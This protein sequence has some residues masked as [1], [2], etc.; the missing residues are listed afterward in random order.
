MVDE[1][2]PHKAKSVCEMDAEYEDGIEGIIY[3]MDDESI[4][5]ADPY[6]YS[7]VEWSETTLYVSNAGRSKAKKEKHG[8][9]KLTIQA[10]A[11][12]IKEK[13][14]EKKKPKNSE[15][16]G[17]NNGRGQGQGS[18]RGRQLDDG[19]GTPRRLAPTMGVSSLLIVYAVPNVGPVNDDRTSKQIA[20]ELFGTPAN[21][22]LCDP[23]TDCTDDVVSAR[24]QALD[25]SRGQLDI[26]PACGPDDPDLDGIC[27]TDTTG[28]IVNG[29]LEVPLTS[30]VRGQSSGTVV[31]WA[32]A[33]ADAV[34]SAT[35]S[36]PWGDGIHLANFTHVSRRCCPILFILSSLELFS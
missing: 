10:D 3:E 18:V 35:R 1:A 29:V 6:F 16:N 2:E 24:S 31:N 17:G 19:S 30:D 5:A 27:A 14:K 7:D 12:V 13:I 26:V 33:S 15:N 11:Q 28:L 32:T 36:Q 23:P 25:C 20:N 21:A 22:N 8:G 9:G 4:L 34:L